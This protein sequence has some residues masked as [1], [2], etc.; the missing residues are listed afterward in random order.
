M[1]GVT[2]IGGKIGCEAVCSYNKKMA[3]SLDGGTPGCGWRY[4]KSD[5]V[6]KI[7]AKECWYFM[8]CGTRHSP[9]S[10][11]RLTP[12]LCNASHVFVLSAII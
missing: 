11:G 8:L 3:R 7:V 9:C 5:F 4:T 12:Y 10:P 2:C 1:D 6:V